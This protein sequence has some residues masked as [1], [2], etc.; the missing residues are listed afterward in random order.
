MHIKEVKRIKRSKNMIPIIVRTVFLGW[1]EGVSCEGNMQRASRVQTFV[2]FF[3][4]GN[5]MWVL[6]IICK[7]VHLY[8]VHFSV[9]MSYFTIKK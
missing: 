3:D 9:Y 1:E 2:L 4:L 8:Y 6:T 5:I 7:A